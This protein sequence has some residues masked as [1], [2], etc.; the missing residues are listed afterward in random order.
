[1]LAL[2][3]AAA[4]KWW[5]AYKRGVAAVQSGNYQAGIDALQTALNE[6]PNEAP[7]LRPKNETFAYV[8]HYW[9]GV[10]RFNLGD[11]EGAVR[12]WRTSEEQGAVQKTPFYAQLRDWVGRANSQKSRASESAVAGVKRDAS[13]AVGRAVSAQMDAVAA[14]AD[15]SDDY[16]AAQRKLQ[17]AMDAAKGGGSDARTYKRSMDLAQQARDLFASAAD[18]AKKRK[19]ARPG[20]MIARQSQQPAAPAAQPVVVPQPVAPQPQVAAVPVEQP[21]PVGVAEIQPQAAAT[22]AVLS[23][24]PPNPIE[25]RAISSLSAREL[26]DQLQLAYRAF[27]AGE[28]NSSEQLLSEI[29]DSSS[30]AEAYLL[31]GCVRYTRSMLGRTPDM[32]G[33]VSDFRAALKANRKLRLDKRAF[34][35]KLIAFFED[36]K[37]KG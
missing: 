4:E 20:Q 36:V 13:S 18:E 3:V 7:S 19:A 35:P 21:K 12:E 9:L 29:V 16:R 11:V 34:S 17:E 33:T 15:R 37:R 28:L 23:A 1:M 10:A 5:D 14:G 8:P 2:P 30:T 22:A 6:T 32:R 24:P 25:R 31:R 27:A 26:R